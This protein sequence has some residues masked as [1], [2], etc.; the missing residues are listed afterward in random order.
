MDK[1]Q[2]SKILIK[3]KKHL[4]IN[5]HNS[6]NILFPHRTNLNNLKSKKYFTTSTKNSDVM[7]DA[8]I[9]YREKKNKINNTQNTITNSSMSTCL[10]RTKQSLFKF[11]KNLLNNVEPHT[12]TSF[13]KISPKILQQSSKDLITNN[14]DEID[15]LKIYNKTKTELTSKAKNKINENENQKKI[16][17][18]IKQP[19]N[20]N[21]N[22]ESIFDEDDLIDFDMNMEEEEFNMYNNN[23]FTDRNKNII[24][25]GINLNDINYGECIK[26]EYLFSELIKDF[27]I[28]KMNKFEN[29]LNIIKKFL[30]IFNDKINHNLFLAFD[31]NS[32][33][34]QYNNNKN[35]EN[36]FLIIKE[37]LI[38]QI[39]F[40][41]IIIL[42]GLIKNEK[43][44]NIYLSGLQNLSF[45]FHQNF[46]VFNFIL[47]SKITNNNIDLLS[48]EA[49]ENY[50]KCMNM[51]RENKTWLNE[52]NYIKCLQI[53]NKMSKQVIKNLF[54]QI[55]IY[56]NSNPYFEK[57]NI[58]KNK[59]RNINIKLKG[60]HSQKK[61]KTENNTKNNNITNNI[62]LRKS[63][64]KNKNKVL[65]SK[66]K[67]KDSQKNIIINNNNNKDFIESD[68]NL[69]LEYIKS[70][71]KVKFTSL[72]KDL[73]CSPSINYLIEKVNILDKTNNN[74]KT[75]SSIVKE[76]NKS[77]NKNNSESPD[78]QKPEAPFL[79][80]IDPKYK[81]TLVLDLDET[82]IHHIPLLNTSDYIQIRPGVEEF[83]NELSEFYEI[84]IFTSSLQLYADL[85]INGFD[86][87][88]K[89]NARLYRQHTTKIGN[90]NI[91][92]LAKLGRDLKKVIIIEN[93]PDNYNLQPKNGITVIDYEG[94][95]ND[96]ILFYLKNDLIK[97]AKKNPDD[98][99]NYLKEIQINMNKRGQEIINSSRTI[100]DINKNNGIM[101]NNNRNNSKKKNFF[102][103]KT[104]NDKI[105]EVVNENE[106]ENT[107]IEKEKNFKKK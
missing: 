89:I 39:I 58:Y 100:E 64:S 106:L 28:N 82:L 36:I 73:K 43:E 87:E 85:V 75:N 30:K 88:K 12:K 67:D 46:Q 51:V 14:D 21:I 3:E 1:K 2:K 42:I 95:R 93:S 6:N 74:N 62:K 24:N 77:K 10:T 41:Y 19:I 92:D 50:E 71:K 57:N 83:L 16:I 13:Q 107:V 76:K 18:G 97:L 25:I 84:V 11:D 104:I 65:N 68:I 23:N 33:N 102:K 98:V 26:I 9:K 29:K 60:F 66:D 61:A 69:F 4:N 27:E 22:I 7:K 52:N 17:T 78:E 47:T 63:S 70:Y 34:N 54:E 37:Y 8:L 35:N 45:Y 32:L 20:I 79:K 56:F 91:K 96:D 53:N 48:P 101:L 44:K 90:A 86:T 55:R 59:T 38:Q 5:I 81:Y 103:K 40:F 72:L 15:E 80:P 99:R 105:M 31:M 94:N 49:A